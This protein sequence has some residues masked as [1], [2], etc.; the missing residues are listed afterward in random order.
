MAKRRQR[1]YVYD[2][3]TITL[4]GDMFT[5]LKDFGD[6]AI[7]EA[8]E[9][10]KLFCMQCD[11]VASHISGEPGDMEIA[12]K[13]TRRRRADAQRTPAKEA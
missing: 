11:W 7:D 9:R 10:A 2:Y 8:R 5:D 3:Y 12:Y 4:P 13:V 6:Q 1:K